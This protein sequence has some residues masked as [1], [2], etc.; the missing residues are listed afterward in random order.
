MTTEE[1]LVKAY[2]LEHPKSR[3]Q[4][5]LKFIK[6]TS[7]TKQRGCILCGW[8]GPTWSAQWHKTK[9]ATEAEAYHVAGHLKEGS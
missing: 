1:D 7:A 4:G 5:V 8:E 2:R 6:T 9:R 3:V